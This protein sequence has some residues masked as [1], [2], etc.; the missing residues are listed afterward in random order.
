MLVRS[1]T[2][3]QRAAVERILAE[4]QKIGE[5]VSAR[6]SQLSVT[7]LVAHPGGDDFAVW[8]YDEAT[9]EA[10]P[11]TSDAR[12][13]TRPEVE[14][15]ELDTRDPAVRQAVLFFRPD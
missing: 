9:R 8:A 6:S 15:R 7:F 10:N 13:I 11:V 4:E 3:E 5:L 1:A 2:A 14:P 12:R